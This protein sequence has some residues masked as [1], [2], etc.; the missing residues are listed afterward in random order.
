M[1]KVQYI[2]TQNKRETTE[3]HIRAFRVNT[4]SKDKIKEGGD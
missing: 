3:D 4:A 2:T 1:I